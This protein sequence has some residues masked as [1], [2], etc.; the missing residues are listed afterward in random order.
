MSNKFV[1]IILFVIICFLSTKNS[2]AEVTELIGYVRVMCFNKM[3][4][5]VIFQ[6]NKDKFFAL[7]AGHMVY[8]NNIMSNTV[9]LDFYDEDE[10]VKRIEA[11]V[12]KGIYNP[13]NNK[14]L[15]LLSFDK[16]LLAKYTIKT[17]PL[18]PQNIKLKKG[19]IISSTGFP[20]GSWPMSFTGRLTGVYDNTITYLPA[21]FIGQSGGPLLKKNSE[22]IEEVIGIIVYN[23]C[24]KDING[25]C[26]YINSLGKQT[27][28]GGVSSLNQI[29]KFIQESNLNVTN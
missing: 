23:T 13:A 5:A 15:A 28:Y 1:R 25:N 29:Y 11:S 22:G 9:N 18:A 24:H 21:P 14:D 2:K 27:G 8:N 17:V 20:F 16:T 4:T 10:F 3:G 12:I 6:K 19:D 7:T 26:I